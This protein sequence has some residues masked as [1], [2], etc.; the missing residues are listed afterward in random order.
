MGLEPSHENWRN[1][2]V[3]RWERTFAIVTIEANS[4]PPER[5][6]GPPRL[7]IQIRK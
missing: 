6:L 5:P 2:M 4:L 7:L 3:G 1:S